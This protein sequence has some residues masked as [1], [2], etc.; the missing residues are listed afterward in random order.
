MLSSR[1]VAT[2]SVLPPSATFPRSF[3]VLAVV[4]DIVD[5]VNDEKL[6][7]FVVGNHIA[8]HP[9]VQERKRAALE[10]GRPLPQ[11]EQTS[12]WVPAC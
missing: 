3:D 2:P 11:E 10:E 9:A 5:P 12:K 1:F 6:A 7:A 4:R 8:S